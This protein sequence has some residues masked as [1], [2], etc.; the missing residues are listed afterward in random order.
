MS[1]R[2]EQTTLESQETGKRWQH[3]KHGMGG[4]VNS[5]PGGS[6]DGAMYSLN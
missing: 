5:G 6:D 3:R 2:C 1:C 4:A